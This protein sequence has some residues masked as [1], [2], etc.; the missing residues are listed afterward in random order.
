MGNTEAK[1]RLWVA[2]TANDPE[3]VRNICMK[4]PQFVNEPISDDKKTNAVT[5]AAYLDRPHILAELAAL[6][7]DL[8]RTAESGMS[9]IMWAAAR[10]NLEC[11]KFLLNFNADASQKGPYELTA[12]DYAILYGYYNTAYYLYYNGYLPTKTAEEFAEIKASMQTLY[13]D[14]P[15]ML[16]S[17]E[18]NMPPDVVPYFT[19]PPIKQDLKLVDPV[20]DPNET[21][22]NWV[23][24]VLE[25]EKPPLV[26]RNSLPPELQPQNTLTG[27]LKIMLKLENPLPNKNLTDLEI[28]DSKKVVPDNKEYVFSFDDPRKISY[29]ENSDKFNGP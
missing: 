20:S 24:R 17:L 4:F 11:L 10:G 28:I 22:T 16:M 12:C 9:A 5:R 6:G 13:V 23:D 15:C 27:K 7:A 21:W 25:F 3:T 2:I 1:H 18:R 14:F 8:N 29:D 19:I 26:E